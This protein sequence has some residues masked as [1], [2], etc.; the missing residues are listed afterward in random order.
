MEAVKFSVWEDHPK[1]DLILADP[2]FFEYDVLSVVKNF[3][4]GGFLKEDGRIIVERSV[5]TKE[6][7]EEGFGIESFK[8]VGD[9]LL[10][11]FM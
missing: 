7:D 6:K 8:R 4:A 2:P 11:E 9:S 1:F 5:Q 3:L 10:Y